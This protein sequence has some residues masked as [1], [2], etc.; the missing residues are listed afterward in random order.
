MM[1]RARFRLIQDSSLVLDF[2]QI[3]DNYISK[4]CKINPAPAD[5]D[6]NFVPAGTR[7]QKDL[8][9]TE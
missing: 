7:P 6:E 3:V 2:C 1:R 5:L 4:A 8:S 9:G